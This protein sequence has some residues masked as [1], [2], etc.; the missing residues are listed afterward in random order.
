MFGVDHWNAGRSAIRV[1]PRH[2]RTV[3]LT[4]GVTAAAMKRAALVYRSADGTASGVLPLGGSP[5]FTDHPTLR[6]AA[7]PPINTFWTSAGVGYPWGIAVDGSGKI[8]FAEPGCDFRPTCP[9]DTPPGQIG[10]LNPATGDVQFHALPA[11]PGNQPIF[12]A[13]DDAG[14]LWFTTPNNSMIGEFSPSSGQFVGQWPVTTGSGPWNLTAANGKLWYTE[15]FVSAIGEFDPASHAHQDFQTPSANSFPY[16]IAASGGQVW[17]TENNSSVDR[18]GVLDTTNGNAIS[19]Y[20]IVQPTS[21]TPHL[22]VVDPNGH[23][24]WSEGWSNTIAT[25]DP[26]AATPGSCGVVSG[27]C[28]GFQRFTVPSTG[29]CGGQAHISGIAVDATNRIWLDSSTSAEVGSFTPQTQAFDVQTL[30]NCSAHPHDGLTFDPAGNVWFDEEF[31]NALGELIPAVPA[32]PPPRPGAPP[33]QPAPPGSQPGNAPNPPSVPP[34]NTA[35]PRISGTPTQ[36]HTLTADRGSWANG[37]A[38]FSYT[39]QRCAHTC[40]NIAFDP[41]ASYR[42]TARDVDQYVRVVVTATNA[43]GTSRA[44]S[45]R[46]GPIDPSARRIKAALS[47]LLRGSTRGWTSAK[48]LTDRGS[49]GSFRAPS[50]G[51]LRV[52]WYGR[53]HLLATAAR[54]FSS[55]RP[56]TIKIGLTR[57]GSRLLKTAKRLI[58]GAKATF[59]RGGEPAGTVKRRGLVFRR[60]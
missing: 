53:H 2:S 6:A 21:G 26:A 45:R 28:K 60:P 51:R 8:W 1:P 20:P 43:A 50:S 5:A 49:R 34:A 44:H 41:R 32:L 36:G 27:P 59:I 35:V 38:D 46:L 24:W 29:V 54:R 57:A 55:P 7:E 16:G 3:R 15:Y 12:L 19:E 4:F 18:V 13:F 47:Q 9:A 22:I 33:A 56:A 37:P 58:V 25:L 42:L 48:L 10:E 11:I 23:P 39:W 30:S 52:A 40:A 14:E 17:F 31:I